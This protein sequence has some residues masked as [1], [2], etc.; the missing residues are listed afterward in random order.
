MAPPQFITRT[1]DRQVWAFSALNR[2]FVS[3][4]PPPLRSARGDWVLR[5]ST[6]PVRAERDGSVAPV[7]HHEPL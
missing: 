7:H 3:L 2:A 1:D 5:P 6:E 4:W